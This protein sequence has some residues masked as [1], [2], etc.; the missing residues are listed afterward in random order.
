VPM[1]DKSTS[2]IIVSDAVLSTRYYG[3][4]RPAR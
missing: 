1:T 4:N 2:D 3:K